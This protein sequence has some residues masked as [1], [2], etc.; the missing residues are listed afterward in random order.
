MG[1]ILHLLNTKKDRDLL[2]ETEWRVTE[3][4]EDKNNKQHSYTVLPVK[5]PKITVNED[6]LFRMS[7]Q[8]GDIVLHQLGKMGLMVAKVT[9]AYVEKGRGTYDIFDELGPG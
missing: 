3:V 6:D 9:R 1:G 5:T 4:H 7:F 2:F 8:T